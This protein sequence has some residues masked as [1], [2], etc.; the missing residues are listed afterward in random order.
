LLKEFEL[1]ERR[2]PIPM[3]EPLHP[4]WIEFIR[5]CR[6]LKHGEIEQL[7]I[8]DGLPLIAETVRQ[9]VKFTK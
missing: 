7:K 6:Q 5:Y 1:K 4:A 3:A 9:K 2:D 8:Q